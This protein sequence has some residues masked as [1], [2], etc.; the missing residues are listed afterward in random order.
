MVKINLMG[1]GEEERAPEGMEPQPEPRE[2]EVLTPVPDEEIEE[3]A[4]PERKGWLVPLLGAVGLLAALV[5]LWV[6][7]QGRGKEGEE[8]TVPTEVTQAETGAA[9]ETTAAATEEVSVAERPGTEVGTVGAPTQ[10]SVVPPGAE[11]TATPSFANAVIAPTL[12]AVRQIQRVLEVQLAGAR[13]GLVS[14]ADG[15]MVVELLGKSDAEL[16]AARRAFLSAFPGA[17]LKLNTR[18][19]KTIEGEI[20]RREIFTVGLP[21]S[22]AT[23]PTSVRYVDKK[24]LSSHLRRLAR[25]AGLAVRGLSYAPTVEEDQ[26]IKTPVRFK[27]LGRREAIGKFLNDLAA[28]GLNVRIT[29]VRLVPADWYRSVRDRLLTL[30]LEMDLCEPL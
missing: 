9:Q 13:L 22:Q 24:Q 1:S 18:A 20:Y 16:D 7:L 15:E 14:Q 29:K 6:I 2:G 8:T 25:S 10:P 30:V 3:L 28:S 19:T 26:L 27:A 4:P 11:K 17:Q 5:V 12:A 23:A 21:P